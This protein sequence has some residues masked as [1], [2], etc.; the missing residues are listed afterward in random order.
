M[1]CDPAVGPSYSIATGVSM[2]VGAEERG[3]R[4]PLREASSRSLVSFVEPVE[5]SPQE[6]EDL[7]TARLITRL[8][9]GERQAFADLYAR[10]F[11]R[12][13][14]YLRVL[15][16]DSHEA[17]DVA[18]HVFIKLMSGLPSYER[19]GQP[20][21]AWLF[22]VVRNQARDHLRSTR[23]VDPMA[24]AEISDRQEQISAEGGGEVDGPDLRALSWVTN[25]DLLVL[26]ERLPE[27]QRQVL[28]LR[29]MMGLPVHEIADVVGS[30]SNHVSVM[31]YRATGFLRERL[32]A[33]GR[34]PQSRSRSRM[35]R[36]PRKA[37]VLRLRRFALERGK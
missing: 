33:L 11:D 8:Q 12:V 9:A 17:E 16:K 14:G 7:D 26:I 3:A 37:P 21:R 31:L 32:T 36:C 29:Y 28:A 24:P 13:Y 6:F 25:Q 23:R 10:Y 22:I 30:T 2:K 5:R 19:R 27:T 1:N 20:F 4:P 35:A 18:Q 34:E 15:L